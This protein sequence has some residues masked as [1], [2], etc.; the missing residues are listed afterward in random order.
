M[1]WASVACTLLWSAFSTLAR[2]PP[3][4]AQ[5]IRQLASASG[6]R[7]VGRLLF[8]RRNVPAPASPEKRPTASRAKIIVE[9]KVKDK[10]F[11]SS[12]ISGN[13][14][15]E[16]DTGPRRLTLLGP[17]SQAPFDKEGSRTTVV[18]LPGF[19]R[20]AVWRLRERATRHCGEGGSTGAMAVVLADVVGQVP[21]FPRLRTLELGAGTGLVALA[22]AGRGHEVVAT[23]GDECVLRNLADNVLNASVAE[24]G[25]TRTLRLRWEDRKDNR[26]ASSL[27]PFDLIVGADLLT[28]GSACDGLRRSI[29]WLLQGKAEVILAERNLQGLAS[30]CATDMRED[31]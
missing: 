19:G 5:D 9:I 10:Q 11:A 25:M 24:P 31:G 8:C 18:A 22:L 2:V 21:E 13:W 30:S 1:L 23:D 15:A 16:K 6:C 3:R 29:R 4:A 27:G 14:E 28:D 17:L 20:W 26:K 12:L 7:S